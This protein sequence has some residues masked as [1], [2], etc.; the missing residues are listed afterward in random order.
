[1]GVG[2]FDNDEVRSGDMVALAHLVEARLA[3]DSDKVEFTKSSGKLL[4]LLSRWHEA[5]MNG[6][7]SLMSSSKQWHRIVERHQKALVPDSVSLFSLRQ[8]SLN[9]PYWA[10]MTAFLM[11]IREGDNQSQVNKADLVCSSVK[12]SLFSLFNLEK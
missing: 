1:M 2:G 3:G 9:L 7:P 11:P 10:F 12:V 8:G 6:I 5:V 4:S